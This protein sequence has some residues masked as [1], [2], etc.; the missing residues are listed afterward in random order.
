MRI[1]TNRI[2]PY[3]VYSVFSCDYNDNS[4]VADADI[5][6]NSDN[7]TVNLDITLN[8]VELKNLID[9]KKVGLYCHLDSPVTKFRDVF[10]VKLDSNN[11]SEKNYTLQQINGNIEL[12]CLLISKEDISNFEDS[13]FNGL[14]SGSVVNFPKYATIGYTETVEI[15]I[16]KRTDSNGEV[17]SIFK[18]IPSEEERTQITFDATNE[19]IYIYLPR[20]QYGIYMDYKGQNKRLKAMMINLPVLTEI[21]DSINS[22]AA[23]Y[24]DQPWFD[25]IEHGLKKNGFDSFG[26]DFTTRPALE[27]AQLLLGDITREA[28]DE[29]DRLLGGKE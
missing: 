17:P 27:V 15:E 6:Y 19:F 12:T 1:R 11:H 22:G 28:F 25:V 20:D 16:Q 18:I 7:A 14:Y 3:P 21:I 24:S 8:D 4:F 10:E 9:C 23:D 26:K 5:E 2:Y 13:N 29:F